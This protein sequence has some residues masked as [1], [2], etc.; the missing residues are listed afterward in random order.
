VGFGRAEITDWQPLYRLGTPYV[1]VWLLVVVAAAAGAAH[2]V[3]SGT[4]EPRRLAMV[5]MLGLAA[6][7]VNRLLAFFAIATV[8]CLGREITAAVHEWRRASRAPSASPPAYATTVAA[9]IAGV[10]ML[11]GSVA[12]VRNVRCV[13]VEA[14]QAEPDV[15]AMVVERGLQGRLAVW[16]D[17]GEYAIWHFTPALSVSIDGR[18]ETVFSDEVMEQHL[19][20]YYQPSTRHAFIAETRPD[21]VWLPSTLPVVPALLADGWIARYSG[22]RSVW[23]TRPGLDAGAEASAPRPPSD[24]VPRCFPGP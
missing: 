13:R 24:A 17:W 15:A 18:R 1:A 3:R 5:V 21:H 7:Q 9:V 22:S 10:L 4:W 2:A 6:L 20:F 23:L 19:A 16:F 14:E 12:A 11:G 8:L